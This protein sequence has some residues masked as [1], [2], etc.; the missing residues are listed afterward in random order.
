M[1][2][3]K[4]IQEQIEITIIVYVYRSMLAHWM[5][6]FVAVQSERRSV[7]YRQLQRDADMVHSSSLRWDEDADDLL[8]GGLI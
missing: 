4:T 3:C 1:F 5:N 6:Q 7:G 2:W 8:A